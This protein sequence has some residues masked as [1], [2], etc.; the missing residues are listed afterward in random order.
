VADHA[1]GQA[2]QTEAE[3]LHRFCQRSRQ[4]QILRNLIARVPSRILGS[5]RSIL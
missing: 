4:T 1:S 3:R 2:D 5:Q